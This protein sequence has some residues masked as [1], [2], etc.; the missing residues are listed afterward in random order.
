[1]ARPLVFAFAANPASSSEAWKS[2]K[3]SCFPNGNLRR[4]SASYVKPFVFNVLLGG[5]GSETEL[6]S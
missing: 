3:K 6:R 4:D 2:G 1:M 5:L